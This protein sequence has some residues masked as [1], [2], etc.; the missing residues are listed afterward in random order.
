MAMR[1][2]LPEGSNGPT[3]RLRRENIERVV[4]GKAME[5]YDGASNGNKNRGGMKRASDTC[6]FLSLAVSREQCA[7]SDEASTPSSPSS[8]R[9]RASD[10]QAR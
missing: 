8:H 9:V 5:M 10:R 4:L 3:S 7:D 2:Y 1:L 6:V